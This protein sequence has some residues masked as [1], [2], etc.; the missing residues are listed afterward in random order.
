MHRVTSECKNLFTRERRGLRG[1]ERKAAAVACVQ[2]YDCVI[3]F[4]ESKSCGQCRLTSRRAS[5]I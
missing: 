2:F 1:C 5:I 4:Q 3:K